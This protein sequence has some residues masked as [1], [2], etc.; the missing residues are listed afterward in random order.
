M[1]DPLELLRL[2]A[3]L[4]AAAREPERWP[5]AWRA[6]AG[7]FDC[8]QHF[9]DPD[10]ADRGPQEWQRFLTTRCAE[11][12]QCARTASGACGKGPRVDESKRQ[13]CLVAVDHLTHALSAAE[14]WMPEARSHVPSSTMAALDALP[15]PMVLCQPDRRLVFANRPAQRELDRLRWLAVRDGLLS[16][17]DA[18]QDRRLA[19]ALD[20][21]TPPAGSDECWLEAVP[22]QGETADYALRR[23]ASGDSVILLSVIIHASA[24][25]PELLDRIGERRRLPP[26][27]RE[28]AGHLLA[29]LSLDAAAEK[30]GIGRRTARDHLSGLFRA[31]GTARQS[32]LIARLSRETLA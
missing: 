9:F 10:A 14:A 4:H 29:G 11:A 17:P 24:P 32:E 12:G 1:P 23:L 3:D 20:S 5:Q 6:L 18:R 15:V 31:T 25:A 26:R 19:V 27:Q 2:T 22:E 13:A 28:L 7:W 30:M 21:F 8:P 16:I